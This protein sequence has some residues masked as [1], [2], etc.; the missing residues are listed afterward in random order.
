[1][2]PGRE[3]LGVRRAV[4]T[5]TPVA[6]PEYL[7]CPG[8]G[9]SQVPSHQLRDEAG[10]TG[11]IIRRGPFSS[12]PSL[13]PFLSS[14]LPSF[15]FPPSLLVFSQGSCPKLWTRG[16]AGVALLCPKSPVRRPPT[17]PCSADVRPQAHMLG[18]SLLHPSSPWT[19]CPPRHDAPHALCAL[20]ARHP[21]QLL[22]LPSLLTGG[23]GHPAPSS[24]EWEVTEGH[25]SGSAPCPARNPE[26]MLFQAWPKVLPMAWRDP[27]APATPWSP[28]PALFR[29][30][31][32][33]G[34]HP[35]SLVFLLK[36]PGLGQGASRSVISV[37]LCPMTPVPWKHHPLLPSHPWRHLKATS[38]ATFL[39]L[40]SE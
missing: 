27:S 17:M 14:F 40:G 16:P 3:T 18:V 24:A 4:L 21:C 23:A 36:Q 22:P 32:H 37:Q 1:M 9:A 29:R 30:A 25:T 34:V 8:P 5:L 20:L 26:C 31:Q 35:G 6:F 38:H 11:V 28:T 15:F 7:V 39:L 19:S 33:L 12:I 2:G 10:A 13:P